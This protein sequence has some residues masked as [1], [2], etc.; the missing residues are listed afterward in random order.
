MDISLTAQQQAFIKRKVKTGL[1][2]SPS[3]VV[4]E[5]LRLLE[6]R[7]AVRLA[8]LDALKK[9][10]AV[11]IAQLDAGL[12]KEFDAEAIKREGR[13]LLARRSRQRP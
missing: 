8:K 4:W 6:E 11:G 10:L 7:D 9:D 12:G 1:Y 13:R 3:D 2:E 5:A